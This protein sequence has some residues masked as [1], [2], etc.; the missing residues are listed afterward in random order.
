MSLEGIA[1]EGDEVEMSGKE[2]AERTRQ[3]IETP[4]I[5]TGPLYDAEGRNMFE[6]FSENQDRPPRGAGTEFEYMLR[7][8]MAEL[9]NREKLQIFIQSPAYKVVNPAVSRENLDTFIC[10]DPDFN[11]ERTEEEAEHLPA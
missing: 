6:F 10:P 4:S 2:A 8:Q 11:T 1:I 7:L 5:F 9:K 3:R